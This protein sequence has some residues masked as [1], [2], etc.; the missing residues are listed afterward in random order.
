[1]YEEEEEELTPEEQAAHARI[2]RQYNEIAMKG[3]VIEPKY[4]YFLG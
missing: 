1:M 2:N 4:K 3:S